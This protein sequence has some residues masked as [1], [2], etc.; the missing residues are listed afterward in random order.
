MGGS[1][2]AISAANGYEI[3]LNFYVAETTAA[4]KYVQNGFANKIH[5][6]AGVGAIVFSTAGNNT[7]G[8]SANISWSERMRLTSAGDLLVGTTTTSGSTNNGSFVIG[9]IFTSIRGT[10]SNTTI[11][12]PTSAVTLPSNYGM[13]LVTA[14]LGGTGAPTTDNACA[15]ITVNGSNAVMTDIKTGSNMVISLSGLTIQLTQKIFTGANIGWNVTRI[16]A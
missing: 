5:G 8:A 11:N 12:T 4:D 16:G 14:I 6:D 7:S 15:L 13:C 1:V 3:G 10:L 9:G 2:G